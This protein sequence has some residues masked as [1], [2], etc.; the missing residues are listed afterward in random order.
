MIRKNAKGIVGGTVW[1]SMF[2]LFATPF[3]ARKLGVPP[4]LGKEGKT[5][6]HLCSSEKHVTYSYMT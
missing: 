2:S 6:T 4:P 3:I 5:L 1:A